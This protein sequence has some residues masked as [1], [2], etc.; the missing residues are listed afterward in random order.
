MA[1]FDQ[2]RP[3]SGGRPLR[4]F[5][6]LRAELALW[7]EARQ[8]RAALSRLSDRELADIG[9]NRADLDRLSDRQLVL[10]R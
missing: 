3:A 6:A 10:D 1:F 4:L 8:T 2:A 9:L 7:R 5:A